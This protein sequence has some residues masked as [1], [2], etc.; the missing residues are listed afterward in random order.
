MLLERIEDKLVGII[1]AEASYRK[2]QMVVEFDET[3][4]TEEQINAEIM[5]MGYE[6][7]A[8]TQQ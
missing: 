3:Q 1:Q 6:I 2:A 7:K 4:V 8:I 5:K